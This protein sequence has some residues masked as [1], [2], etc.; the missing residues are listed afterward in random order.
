VVVVIVN[1]DPYNVQSGILT[2]DPESIG[3]K[4]VQPFQMHDLLS[5]QR[6]LWQGQY[7]FIRLDPHS[8]PAHICV[9]R[10]LTRDERDFD[11]FL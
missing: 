2:L 11:Y 9:V 5:N 4:P 3:V 8:V 7:I 1:L 10:R 6:F